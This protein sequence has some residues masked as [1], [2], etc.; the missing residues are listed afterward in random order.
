MHDDANGVSSRYR[1]TTP[2]REHSGH[3]YAHATALA[4]QRCGS[5][6][7]IDHRGS[8]MGIDTDRSPPVIALVSFDGS[9]G[10]CTVADKQTPLKR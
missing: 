3:T 2:R 9:A 5:T 7:L 6:S 8:G 1:I 10:V 4:G